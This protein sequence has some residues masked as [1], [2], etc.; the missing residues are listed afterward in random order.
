[1]V[2]ASVVVLAMGLSACGPEGQERPLLLLDAQARAAG[3]RLTVG[4]WSGAPVTPIAVTPV[5]DVVLTGPAG[6]R[7]L[8]PKPGAVGQIEGAAGTLT[9]RDLGKDVDPDRFTVRGSADAARLLATRLDLKAEGARVEG[10]DAL[11]LAAWFD[12]PAEVAELLT[13]PLTAALPPQ[14]SMFHTVP[15]APPPSMRLLDEIPSAVG[16]YTTQAGELLVLDASGGFTQHYRCDVT[17]G[18]FFVSGNTVVLVPDNGPR[19]ELTAG[20]DGALSDNFS[21][22]AEGHDP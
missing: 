16:A 8:V 20:P 9:W 10:P 4:E 2:R 19:R 22:F 5:D 18:H 13:E 6:T 7:H 1:M 3:Y 11:T 15:S 17:T 21:R 12:A 14:P